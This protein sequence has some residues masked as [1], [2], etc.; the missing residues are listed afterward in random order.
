M[1]IVIPLGLLVFLRTIGDV[2]E[3]S[4]ESRRS[5]SPSLVKSLND[6]FQEIQIIERSCNL[7][8][9]LLPGLHSFV[10][11]KFPCDVR[12]NAL[13]VIKCVVAR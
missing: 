11:R 8:Y 1:K 7:G 2:I 13:Q 9:F 5:F 3:Q 10:L 12:F 4:S 6:T